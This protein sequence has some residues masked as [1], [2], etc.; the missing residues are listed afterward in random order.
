[1]TIKVLSAESRNRRIRNKDYVEL[2]KNYDELINKACLAN[3][4]NLKIQS[5][6]H[7]YCIVLY[8]SE[9]YTVP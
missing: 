2:H 1:V 4:D 8:P 5:N 6:G 7:V 3:Q 9:I